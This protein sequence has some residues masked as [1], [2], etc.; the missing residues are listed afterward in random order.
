MKADDIIVKIRE[1]AS[2][3]PDL[4]NN[5]HIPA[6]RAANVAPNSIYPVKSIFYYNIMS[7]R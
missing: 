1:R 4:S 2:P 7:R 3:G 6:E 5:H